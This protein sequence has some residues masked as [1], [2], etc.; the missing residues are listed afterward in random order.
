MSNKKVYWRQ[1]DN[2]AIVIIDNPPANALGELVGL[3]IIESLE[4]IQKNDEIRAVVLTGAGEKFF[5]AGADISEFPNLMKTPSGKVAEFSLESGKTYNKIDFFPKP[6]I[7]AVNGYALGGGCEVVLACD[8]CVAS[9]NA[10]FGLPEINLGLFPGGGGTQRLPRRIG[11]ARA[12]ELIFTGKH[13]K[14]EEALEIGLINQVVE[15]GQAL[16][17]AKKLAQQIAGQPAVAINLIKK[18]IDRGADVALLDALKIEADLFEQ[19]FRTED[20]KEG[21]AAF[22]E[23]RKANFKHR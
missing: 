13:I 7:A 8:L 1:E 16:E 2:I 21:V 17:E 11:D 10:R 14:A 9:K 22:M 18:S 23:K 5:I 6:I 19:V 4:E 12:K 20:V 15:E 3:Q